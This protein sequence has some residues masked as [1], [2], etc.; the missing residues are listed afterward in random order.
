MLVLSELRKN[1]RQ[2]IASIARKL[3]IPLSTCHDNYKA[4]KH[5]IKKHTSLIDFDKLGYSLRI[6]FTFKTK[7]I[8]PILNNK[9]IN[10]IY[11]INNKNTFLAEC[12]FRNINEAYEFKENLQELGMKHI[13]MSYIIDEIKKETTF[14]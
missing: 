9:H 10:S 4:V 6:N 12:F 14:V 3:N 7:D 2:S 5:C 8:H 13:R 1:S 11:R